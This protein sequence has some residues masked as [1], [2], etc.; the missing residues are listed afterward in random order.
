MIV[1]ILRYAN[2]AVVCLCFFC[3]VGV[4][5]IVFILASV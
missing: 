5:I 2:K 1:L 3:G 4:N